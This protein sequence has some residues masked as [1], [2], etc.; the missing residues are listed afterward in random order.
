MV[1]V[2]G[3]AELRAQLDPDEKLV[4]SVPSYRNDIHIEAQF[5]RRVDNDL[6]KL[7][8]W[9]T[10]K[11]S[12]QVWG[13]DDIHAALDERLF[14]DPIWCGEMRRLCEEHFLGLF[15]LMHD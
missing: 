5:H 10:V 2:L 11:G 8:W 13:M 6:A 4:C 3:R 12:L 14:P 1:T 9:D 7:G 15:G